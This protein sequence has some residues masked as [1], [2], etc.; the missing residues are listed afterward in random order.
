MKMKM[1]IIWLAI[2]LLAIGTASA[3][4]AFTMAYINI[5]SD[6]SFQVAMPSD[7]TSFTDITG[8]TAATAT[9]TNWISF[10]LTSCANGTLV[11]PFE[12][13]AAANRQLSAENKPMFYI[14]NSGNGNYAMSIYHND[15][16]PTGVSIYWNTTCSASGCTGGVALLSPFN[17]TPTP[18]CTE[19]QPT[20]FLNVSFWA[21]CTTGTSAGEDS[22]GILYNSTA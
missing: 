1:P 22:I 6:T 11:E 7:F 8:T 5:P 12:L 4:Y 19:L 18:M 3:E 14:D 9:G 21:N 2:F 17:T 20:G 10:N 15:T 16:M 13:G